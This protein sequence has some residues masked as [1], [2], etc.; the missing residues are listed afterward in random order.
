MRSAL[1]QISLTRQNNYAI[2]LDKMNYRG[3]Q[4]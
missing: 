1:A 2:V 3:T 4:S